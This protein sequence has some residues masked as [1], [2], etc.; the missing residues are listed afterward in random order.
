M[1]Q[2]PTI[3]TVSNS[4][5]YARLMLT[6]TRATAHLLV[7]LPMAVLLLFCAKVP[8]PVGHGHIELDENTDPRFVKPDGEG[9]IGFLQTR[10]NNVFLNQRPVSGGQTITKGDTIRTGPDSRASIKYG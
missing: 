2:T 6:P 4:T 5:G 10:G 1:R 8:L 9:R 3:S 7:L